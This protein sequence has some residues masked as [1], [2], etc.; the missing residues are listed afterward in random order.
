MKNLSDTFRILGVEARLKIVTLLLKSSPLCVS[1]ITEQLQISQSAV[2]QHLRVLKM[3][4][5]VKAEKIGYW[6]H[7]SLK[8]KKLEELRRAVE[9]LV[10]Q[11]GQKS[12]RS[13]SKA[14]CRK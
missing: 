1:A 5:W 13:S 8:R 11:R 4:G 9:K 14:K 12:C 10:A 3:A 7:Y 2:S 6:V